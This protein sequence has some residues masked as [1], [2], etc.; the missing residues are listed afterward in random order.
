MGPLIPKDGR[1]SRSFRF[2]ARWRQGQNPCCVSD[3]SYLHIQGKCAP[4]EVA[5]SGGQ[6]AI[7]SH[8]PRGETAGA[9]QTQASLG[10]QS[11]PVSHLRRME[12]PSPPRKGVSAKSRKPHQNGGTCWGG[13]RRPLKCLWQS[14]DCTALPFLGSPAL[15]GQR[16]DSRFLRHPS[17]DTREGG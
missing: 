11:A 1:R 9:V 12:M 10:R 14:E 16:G 6:K 2:G 5:G 17:P 15:G 8:R 7:K 3:V 13:R 4:G